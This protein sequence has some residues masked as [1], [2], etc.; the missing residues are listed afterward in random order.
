M[1]YFQSMLRSKSPEVTT[2][3]RVAASNLKTTSGANNDMIMDVGLGP[4]MVRQTLREQEP[5]QT[6]EQMARLY[7]Y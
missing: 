5:V 4:R 3:A 7:L 1:K 2:I 6:L